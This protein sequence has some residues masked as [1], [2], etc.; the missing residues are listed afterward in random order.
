[1]EFHAKNNELTKGYLYRPS[2]ELISTY[3]V[4]CASAL[5]LFG[6]LR[7][8]TN[9]RG[10]FNLFTTA[11]VTLIL[12]MIYFN[13]FSVCVRVSGVQQFEHANSKSACRSRGYRAQHTKSFVLSGNQ[14]PPLAKTKV[15]THEFRV[16]ALCS[17][18]HTT[19]LP[20]SSFTLLRRRCSRSSL[21]WI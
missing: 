4:A 16:C 18:V 7:C 19:M 21:L 9:R 13:N 2:P 5:R 10:A 14:L 12:S 1:M 15:N 8:I 11:G 20:P 17:F 3:L 6:S